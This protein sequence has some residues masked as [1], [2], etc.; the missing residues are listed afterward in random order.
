MVF[1][2]RSFISSGSGL[3]RKKRNTGCSWRRAD[4]RLPAGPFSCGSDYSPG[5]FSFYVR[6]YHLE[7]ASATSPLEPAAVCANGCTDVRTA[8]GGLR[9]R[10]CPVNHSVRVNRKLFALAQLA[11]FSFSHTDAL[12]RSPLPSS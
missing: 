11:I 7:A 1:V 12:L 3:A 9:V 2:L 5:W 4:I 10:P 6:S 8:A